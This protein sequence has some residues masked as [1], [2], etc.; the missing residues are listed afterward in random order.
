MQIDKTLPPG[1]PL[2]SPSNSSPPVQLSRFVIKKILV[3]NNGIENENE[4]VKTAEVTSA[5]LPNPIV[6]IIDS[7]I[8]NNNNSNNNNLTIINNN[9]TENQGNEKRISKFIVK[10]VGTQILYQTNLKSEFSSDV[11]STPTPEDDE[12]R[13]LVVEVGAFSHTAPDFK[14]N[15]ESKTNGHQGIQPQDQQILQTKLLEYQ[16]QQIQQQQLLLN[17]SSQQ[18]LQ[19]QSTVQMQQQQTQQQPQLAQNQFESQETLLL[20]QMIEVNAN[21]GIFANHITRINSM[22]EKSM[23]FFMFSKISQN[24][25]KYYIFI[26][27]LIKKNS[28]P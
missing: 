17:A 16:Q 4:T 21:K 25:N 24:I 7:T 28:I 22:V 1:A 3:N 11:C 2:P 27:F 5:V 14:N 9:N 20:P 10:K 26:D 19:Q 6:E 18:F 15:D 13:R 12:R 23:F 8:N